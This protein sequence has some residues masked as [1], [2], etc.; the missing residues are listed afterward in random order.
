MSLAFLP[1]RRPGEGMVPA[2]HRHLRSMASFTVIDRPSVKRWPPMLV[3]PDRMV[4]PLPSA[5]G[6]LGRSTRASRYPGTRRISSFP[7]SILDRSHLHAGGD[8][9]TAI[10]ET[11]A[12]A[13]AA[14]ARGFH[15]FWVSEHHG[16]P[17]VA[18][19]APAVLIA[20]LG[21]ETR[22]IRLGSGG[23]MVPNHQPLVIAEQFGT[24]DIL[25]PGRIDLGMGRSLGFIRPVRAALRRDAYDTDDFARDIAEIVSYLDGTA[26]VRAS[27]GEGADVQ[28]FVLANGASAL[29]AAH[30]GLPL[31]IGGPR[32]LEPDHDGLTVIER[33]RQAFRPSRFAPEPQVILAVAALA[34][35]DDATGRDLALPEAWAFVDATSQGA[36]LPMESPAA[37]RARTL[38]PRQQVK[39]EQMAGKAV[40]GDLATVSARIR[41]LVAATGADEVLLT[42]TFHALEVALHSDALIAEAFGLPAR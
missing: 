41:E 8:A 36:Y 2:R 14:E 23:V 27:P 37:I 26:A 9:A 40:A 34:A 11:I 6:R 39:L 5:S 1:G 22:H 30:A 35:D 31:V 10:R 18:G 38:T 13:K 33:Y 29:V 42:G 15:R 17:G 25:F 24:L 3:P 12:R 4:G 21:Q 28:P 20:A 16:V 32:L 7:I 19:A